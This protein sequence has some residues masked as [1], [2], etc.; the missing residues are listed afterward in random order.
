MFINRPPQ[1][2]HENNP[3]Q[4]WHLQEGPRATKNYC[5]KQHRLYNQPTNYSDRHQ[6]LHIRQL[7]TSS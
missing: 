5:G 2:T 1:R 6:Y 4:N 3:E 7:L